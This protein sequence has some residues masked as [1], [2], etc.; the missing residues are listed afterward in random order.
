MENSVL[1]HPKWV[2]I[3]IFLEKHKWLYY[4]L[5]HTWGIVMTLAGYLVALCLLICGIKPIGYHG[6]FHFR[7]KKNWGG[8]NFGM[9]FL[10]DT[11]S[12]EH[13]TKHELGHTYQNCVLGPLFLFIVAIPSACRYWYQT[14]AE[15]HGKT[16]A[17]DWYD[18]AWFEGSATEIGTYIVDEFKKEGTQ[19]D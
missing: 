1:K 3:G 12:T 18:S 4:L 2:K 13:V 5:A 9:C 11:T 8:L 17:Y 10:R 19:N 16:F 15:K 14:I 6:I 7:L